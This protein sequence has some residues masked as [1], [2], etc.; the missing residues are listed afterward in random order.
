MIRHKRPERADIPKLARAAGLGV[1]LL[2]N[3]RDWRKCEGNVNHRPRCKSI[4]A[5]YHATNMAE[6]WSRN[7][8]RIPSADGVSSSSRFM[9]EP[10]NSAFSALV[11]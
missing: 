9:M 8:A 6:I 11:A 2:N 10:N 7:A 3:Y 4:I 5:T 1:S